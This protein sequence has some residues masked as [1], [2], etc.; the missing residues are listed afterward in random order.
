[1]EGRTGAPRSPTR[2]RRRRTRHLDLPNPTTELIVDG[3]PAG[4]G[5]TVTAAIPTADRLLNVPRGS[6]GCGVMLR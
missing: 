1:V 4:R 6:A 2:P 3:G 5:A